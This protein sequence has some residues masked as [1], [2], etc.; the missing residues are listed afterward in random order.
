MLGMRAWEAE[1]EE[2]TERKTDDVSGRI[3]R[4]FLAATA[5]FA[6][7]E[8]KQVHQGRASSKA[9]ILYLFT[10]LFIYFPCCLHHFSL[11]VS[12]NPGAQWLLLPT[13]LALST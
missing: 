6:V 5:R 1:E 9:P 2:D 3:L 12:V 11:P 13:F 7:V 8:R 10:H 4:G